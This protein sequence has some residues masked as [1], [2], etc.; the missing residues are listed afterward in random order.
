MKTPLHAAC[1]L[2]HLEAVVELLKHPRVD[3]NCKVLMEYTRF[4]E[5]AAD[6][7]VVVRQSESPL[8]T[9]T[10]EGHKHIAS[11]LI[12]HGARQ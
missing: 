1:E 3:I 10:R 4:D 5:H 6:G 8:D 11:L 12:S 2:G 7:F 9:A